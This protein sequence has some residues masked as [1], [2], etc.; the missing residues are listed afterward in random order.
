MTE[1]EMHIMMLVTQGSTN[2][3]IAK[4]IHMSKR[5]VDNYL[6]KIYDKLGVRARAQAVERFLQLQQKAKMRNQG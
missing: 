3:Q 5:S 6:K 4:D 2:E 1:D